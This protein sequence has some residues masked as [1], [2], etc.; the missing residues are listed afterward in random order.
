[1]N[2]WYCL[3]CVVLGLSLSFALAGCR[4]GAATADTVSVQGTVKF[5]GMPVVGAHVTFAPEDEDGYAAFGRT[6][7]RGQYTLTTISPNDGAVPGN[8]KVMISKSAAKKSD[9][10]ADSGSFDMNSP[11]YLAYRKKQLKKV[12]IAS[13]AKKDSAATDLLPSKYASKDST[14]LSA[15]VETNNAVFD[16]DLK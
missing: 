11:E 8:Y 15:V 1:M 5:Q 4:R 12:G 6:N 13:A 7:E 3:F 9:D 14:P 2:R 16:F 10:A